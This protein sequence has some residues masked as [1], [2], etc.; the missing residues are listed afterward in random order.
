MLADITQWL[1]QAGVILLW[2]LIVCSCLLAL[3]LSCLSLSGT[4]IVSLAAIGAMIQRPD[5]FPGWGTITAFLLL[6]T[7]VEWVEWVAGAWGVTQRGGSSPAGVAAIVGGIAGL[8][9]GGL[10][11]V[12]IVG[13]LIGML[14]G[15]FLL[16]FA[17]EH[18]RLN[19][20]GQAAHIARGAVIAR[21][22]VIILK[23]TVTLGMIVCLAWGILPGFS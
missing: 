7:T 23:V 18:R 8:F 13:S 14:A 20:T 3:V 10:I 9:I 21:V 16:A 15:S 17:V 12:P 19:H 6:S 1:A 2:T 11:P 4:W 22:L 5:A